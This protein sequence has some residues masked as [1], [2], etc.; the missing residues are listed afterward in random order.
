MYTNPILCR[1]SPTVIASKPDRFI[2]PPLSR[3]WDP[4]KE[5]SHSL[6]D[7]LASIDRKCVERAYLTNDVALWA[8]KELRIELFVLGPGLTE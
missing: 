2:G 8:A 6:K 1:K 5:E 3:G 7:L 4:E